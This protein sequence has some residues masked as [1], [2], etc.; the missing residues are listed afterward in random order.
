[1]DIARESVCSRG[2][3]LR[4]QIRPDFPHEPEKASMSKLKTLISAM[5]SLA[6]VAAPAVMP[7]HAAGNLLAVLR[8]HGVRHPV[9]EGCQGRDQAANGPGLEGFAGWPDLHV[10]A[11]RRSE[12]A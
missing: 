10:H 2:A 5:F 1:M 8:I 9:R 11:T 12:M 3:F 6:L 4:F 7:A